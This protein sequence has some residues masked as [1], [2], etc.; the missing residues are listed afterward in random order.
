[1]SWDASYLTGYT[2]RALD[3]LDQLLDKDEHCRR[4]T[5]AQKREP[6]PFTFCGR[7]RR[8]DMKEL[9]PGARLQSR[10]ASS[11]SNWYGQDSV[12]SI[13]EGIQPVA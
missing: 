7:E 1:M 10:L 3:E 6:K 11:R 8:A 4:H 13:N 5:S 2:A 9:D 12:T